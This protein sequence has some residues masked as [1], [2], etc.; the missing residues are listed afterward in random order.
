MNYDKDYPQYLQTDI[1]NH[2]KIY[3]FLKPL[4]IMLFTFTFVVYITYTI[5]FML[6]SI[7]PILGSIQS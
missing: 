1:K 7:L 5:M 2:W 4:Y 6:N 3:I